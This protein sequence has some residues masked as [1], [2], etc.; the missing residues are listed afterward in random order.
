MAVGWL[1]SL[2]LVS[3][4]TAVWIVLRRRKQQREHVLRLLANGMPAEF[5]LRKEHDWHLFL[6]HKWP[7]GQEPVARIRSLLQQHAPAVKTFLDV[8]ALRHSSISGHLD[9][10]H[11]SAEP[12]L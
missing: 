3:A 11:I 5:V 9:L 12:P 2:V 4:S 6:S 1:V 10:G 8:Y 7:T